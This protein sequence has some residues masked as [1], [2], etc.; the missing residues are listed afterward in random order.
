MSRTVLVV[1]DEPDLR[2]L[3][4]MSLELVG[5]HRVVAAGS[6]EEA[7]AALAAEQPDAVL[8]DVQMPDMD[9]PSTLHAMTE[10]AGTTGAPLPPVVFITA[11]VQDSELSQLL[12]LPIAGVM[13]KPF[14]S[15]TMP[16]EFEAILGW[17]R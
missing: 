1:D 11:S 7:L 10:A 8:M 4:T 16:S 17:E 9:G 13:Q 15:M 12:R 2:S 14:D 6:G 5:G 3:M